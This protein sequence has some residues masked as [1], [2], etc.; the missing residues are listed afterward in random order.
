MYRMC[1][2]VTVRVHAC[3]GRGGVESLLLLCSDVS[4]LL[5]GALHS[6]HLHIILQLREGQTQVQPLDSDKCAALQ[7]PC[8][9]AYLHRKKNEITV[10]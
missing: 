8:H 4:L 1:V 6:C 10:R 7:R 2:Q 3:L 9:R 5:W